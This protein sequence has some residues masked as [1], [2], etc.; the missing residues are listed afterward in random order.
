MNE[1][2]IMELFMLLKEKLIK[3]VLGAIN[4]S[5]FQNLYFFFNNTCMFRG[6]N[7]FIPI[8]ITQ[9]LKYQIITSIPHDLV[10]I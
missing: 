4:M 10:N 1:I 5:P 8:Q 2:N 3:F 6:G 9:I 7:S